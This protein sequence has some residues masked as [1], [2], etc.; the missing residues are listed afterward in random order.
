MHHDNEAEHTDGMSSAEHTQTDGDRAILT[1]F[2]QTNG[3]VDGLS[4]D[5]EFAD[6]GDRVGDRR[7]GDV[8][9]RDDADE[10]LDGPL[11]TEAARDL[12]E[13]EQRADGERDRDRD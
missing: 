11:L 6:D 13:G 4:G 2:D 7:D 10:G 1:D 3:K 5:D 8:T 9:D 12:T